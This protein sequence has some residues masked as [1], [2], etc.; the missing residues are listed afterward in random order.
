M[1]L[2][3]TGNLIQEQ[4]IT[5]TYEARIGDTSYEEL[6]EAFAMHRQAIPSQSLRTAGYQPHLKLLL[7][8]SP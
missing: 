5:V 4:D 2:C 1:A 3:A 7:I 6:E 8:T